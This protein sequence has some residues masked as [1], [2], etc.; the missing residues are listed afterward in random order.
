MKKDIDYSIIWK[1]F[2]ASLSTSEEKELND[3][4]DADIKHLQHFEKLKE[5]QPQIPH[6]DS[7]ISNSDIAWQNIRLTPKHPKRHFWK[8]GVA[9][10]IL[11]IVGVYS[12]YKLHIEKANKIISAENIQIE[13]GV[14]KATLVLNSGQKLELESKKDTL[15]KEA[16]VTIENSN[17]ELN[18]K[19]NE[20]EKAPKRAKEI[21]YNTLIVPR[22]GEYDLILSDGTE[23]KINSESILRYP[24]V[25]EKGKRNVELIGEAFFHVKTDSLRPFFVTSAEHQVKVYGTSFNVKSYK[26]DDYIATTLVSGKVTVSS[27]KKD[28]AEQL[29]KPGYQSIYKKES[30]EFE[31]KQVDIKE[32]TAWKDGRFYFRNMPLEEIT[33]ILARW[34]DVDFKFKNKTVKNLTFNGNLKR[35]DNIQL[36]LNQ[37]GKT[38]EITFYAYDQIIYVDKEGLSP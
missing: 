23:V 27:D 31:Q 36:I 9:A 17:S 29:L 19:K 14:K 38:N 16:E 13:P 22:G 21:Q 30:A 3:W 12:G 32:F 15:I 1:Y 10:S 24:V 26:N 34:Y 8:I 4:L 33:Q 28:A 7:N 37:L 6:T 5:K 25:F 18:Y 20:K 2:N 11:L 35:Y